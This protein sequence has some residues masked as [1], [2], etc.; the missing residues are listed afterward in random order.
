MTDINKKKE[1]HWHYVNHIARLEEEI[2]HMR[3]R[4]EARHEVMFLLVAGITMF[5]VGAWA[6]HV[7]L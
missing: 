1:Y 6:G 3:L 7:F 4:E 5:L 2:Q